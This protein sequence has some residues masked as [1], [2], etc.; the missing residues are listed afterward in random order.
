[1]GL[2]LKHAA[3]AAGCALVLVFIVAALAATILIG[4]APTR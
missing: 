3:T 1:M 4:L 2:A